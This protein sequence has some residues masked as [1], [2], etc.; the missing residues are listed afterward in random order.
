M[1]TCEDSM[2]SLLSPSASQHIK[3]ATGKIVEYIREHYSYWSDCSDEDL[4]GW[5]TWHFCK[6]LVVAI[7]DP[8]D[9]RI[10]ALVIARMF[11]DPQGF[12]TDFLHRRNGQICYVELAIADEPTALKAAIDLFLLRHGVPV[13][14]MHERASRGIGVRLRLWKRYGSLLEAQ[15]G[16]K[17]T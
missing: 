4:R 12:D 16:F 13:Y 6:G 7:T 17:Q 9:G 1:D 10:A 11:D 2:L 15:N 5:L 3:A 8:E 14:I